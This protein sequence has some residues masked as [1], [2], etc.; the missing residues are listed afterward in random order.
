MISFS[1]VIIAERIFQF[2]FKKFLWFIVFF[3]VLKKLCILKAILLILCSTND[4][5]TLFCSITHVNNRW[6]YCP[7]FPHNVST[8][9]ISNTFR[10]PYAARGWIRRFAAVS[11]SYATKKTK[12]F[13]LNLHITTYMKD[14]GR[15]GLTHQ[16][17]RGHKG[18][19]VMWNGAHAM[20]RIR[21]S[22]K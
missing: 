14:R 4:T 10:C 3:R 2:S 13:R 11:L 5:Y 17:H 22:A 18:I 1:T 15:G 6:T 19:I 16:S 21:N 12:N 20:A 7:F 9:T 8:T